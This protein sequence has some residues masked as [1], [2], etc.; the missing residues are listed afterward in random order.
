[1]LSERVAGDINQT[2]EDGKNIISKKSFRVK[3]PKN[4]QSAAC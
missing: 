3:S 2:V 1:M 4:V